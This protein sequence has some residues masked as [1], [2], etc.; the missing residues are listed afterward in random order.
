MGAKTLVVLINSTV[1][2]SSNI[3]YIILCN[4]TALFNDGQRVICFYLS[5]WVIALLILAALCLM[6]ACNVVSYFQHSEK[7]K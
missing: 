5:D 3:N 1:A 4:S 2:L 6:V 7:I